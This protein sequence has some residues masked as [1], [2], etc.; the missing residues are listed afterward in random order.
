MEKKIKPLK[1]VS[2]EI[3]DHDEDM[4]IVV[5]NELKSFFRIL[6]RRSDG[7]KDEISPKAFKSLMKYIR[8]YDRILYFVISDII[9]ADDEEDLGGNKIGTIL[10]N[11]ENLVKYASDEK[12]IAD[13]VNAAKT[14]DEKKAVIDTKKAVWKIWDHVNLAHK[15]YLSLKQSD[16][17][18]DDKFKTRINEFKSTIVNEMNGQL[19]SMVGMFTALAFILFGGIDSMA[20]IFSKMGTTSLLKL[21]IIGCIWGLC[22]L[23]VVFVFLFCVGKMTNSLF[24]ST[25]RSDASFFQRYPVVCWT[26]FVL[27]VLITVFSWMYYSIQKGADL[28]IGR[29]IELDPTIVSVIG[30]VVIIVLVYLLAKRL[31]EKTRP[32]I[33]D[34]DTY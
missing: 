1:G 14:E 7:A 28:W 15:Q 25:K 12:T 30:L 31:I 3:T 18:Y 33:G 32:L 13:Y 24:K 5:E 9:Y 20:N 23:N 17:E 34:E 16:K 6:E 4:L 21:A 29:I 2:S 26:D 19:L 10:T 22:I 27:I 8:V 11:L